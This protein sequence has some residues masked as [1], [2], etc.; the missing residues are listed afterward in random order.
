MATT[1]SE[2]VHQRIEGFSGRGRSRRST[3]THRYWFDGLMQ[4]TA[5]AGDLKAERWSMLS[6][7]TEGA[8]RKRFTGTKSFPEAAKL[9]N[10][11]WKKGRDQLIS[12]VETLALKKD[13][14]SAPSFLYDVA[15][16]RP[17][18]P[19]AVA[20][21]PC[22][23]W[24]VNPVMESKAPTYRLFI[25]IS[26][27]CQWEAP[28]LMK[29]GA[30]I[31]SVVDSLEAQGDCSLEINI[32]QADTDQN[33]LKT[34][35]IIRLKDAGQHLDF[36]VMAF[37]I[38]HP[39]MLRRVMFGCMERVVADDAENRMGCGYGRPAELDVDVL[40]GDLY[41]PGIGNCGI[42]E[43]HFGSAERLFP[44]VMKGFKR[45]MDGRPFAN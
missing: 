41:V 42:P 4:T 19:L 29:W 12:Q 32:C 35:F 38:A 1:Y 27:S 11:G 20:G 7:H 22:C 25:N 39:S 9:V 40:G 23:M 6:S 5:W 13:L 45:L 36:D 24:D 21:D 33:G 18:V 14:V 37:A 16:A 8:E 2:P 31:L 17:E 15:G 26:A 30:C 44:K 43:H 10:K 3:I 34:E 28:Q